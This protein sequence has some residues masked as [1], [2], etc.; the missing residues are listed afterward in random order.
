MPS[1]F[2]RLLDRSRFAGLVSAAT[3]LIVAVASPSL[4]QV[5]TATVYGTVLDSS[6]SIVPGATVNLTH[7]ETGGSQTKTT[8]STGEFAFDFLRVGTY[9]IRIEAPGFK[10]FA[11]SGIQLVAGQLGLRPREEVRENHLYYKMF[12]FTLG[13]GPSSTPHSCI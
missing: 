2:A 6:G 5:T 4:A 13:Y 9:S 7:E 3:I 10:S 8:S 12:G 11:S 1:S